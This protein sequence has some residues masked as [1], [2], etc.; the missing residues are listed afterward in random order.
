MLEPDEESHCLSALWSLAEADGLV[1][2]EERGLFDTFQRVMGGKP[3][4][5]LD[6]E[7]LA[8]EVPGQ[9]E[10]VELIRLLLMLAIADGKTSALEMKFV[11]DIA[12]ELSV[13]RAQV[14]EMRHQAYLSADL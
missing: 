10:R 2:A 9:L 1:S 6:F 5:S 14:D 3:A 11:L 4:Q 12:E 7:Q 8:R 13:S